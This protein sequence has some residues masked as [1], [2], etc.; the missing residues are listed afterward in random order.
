MVE[1]ITKTKQERK[2]S[3]AEFLKEELEYRLKT[4]GGKPDAMCQAYQEAIAALIPEEK[5]YVVTVDVRDA[6]ACFVPAPEPEEDCEDCD[7]DDYDDDPFNDDDNWQDVSGCVEYTR[8]R[9]KSRDEAEKILQD[10]YPEYDTSYFN[11]E[12]FLIP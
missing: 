1:S 12:E 9:A 8:I 3:A 6:Q 2:E 7:E 10:K 4:L 5:L 11:I